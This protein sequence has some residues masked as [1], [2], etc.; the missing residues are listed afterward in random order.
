MQK[1]Y[2][3]FTHLH[4]GY[5][6]FYY[7]FN[8]VNYIY[9]PSQNVL[10]PASSSTHPSLHCPKRTEYQVISAN[11][12]KKETLNLYTV[13][14]YLKKCPGL[15]PT[16]NTFASTVLRGL[17]LVIDTTTSA[18]HSPTAAMNRKPTIE[19]EFYVLML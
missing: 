11:N 7:H 18:D 6:I 8:I 4:Y 13:L 19:M 1:N 5:A 15:S 9:N 10:Q 2:P 12:N 3:L 14:V 16:E 17:R